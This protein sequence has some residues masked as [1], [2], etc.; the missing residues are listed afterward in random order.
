MAIIKFFYFIRKNCF[1]LTILKWE[2]EMIKKN[3]KYYLTGGLTDEDID[4]MHVAMLDIIEDVGLKV[5]HDGIL[6]LLAGKDGV[7]IKGDIVKFKPELVEK[8]ISEMEYPEYAIN[9]DYI[10]NGGAYEMNVI[11]LDSGKIRPALTSDLVDMVKLVDSYG[12]YASSPVRPTDIKSTELQEIT[13]YKLC[14]ENSSNV[15]NSIFE[16]NEKSSLRVAEYIYEMAQISGKRYSLGFWVKSPFKVDFKELDIIYE[17][18]DKKVPLWCATMPIAGATAPIYFP[19]AYVQSMAEVFAGL[20]LLSLINTS[21]VKPVC[22]IID[23][24]RAYAFDFKYASFV[25]GSPEDIIGTLFQVQ[26]NKRY[27]IPVVAKSLL[28]SSNSIDTQ[29]GAEVM[30]HTMAAALAGARIF[31]GAGL[32]SIDEVYSGEKLVIDYEVVQYVK[33]VVEGFR[34]SDGYLSTEIIKEVGIGG[35]FVSHDSTLKDYRNATWEPNVFEHIMLRKWRQMGEPELR[36][37]L[38]AV[39]KERISK[40]SYSLSKDVSKELNKLYN[41]AKEEFGG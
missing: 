5:P 35:E 6:K 9:A 24:I 23:T 30:A 7:K 27:G 37:K 38:R 3:R 36:E 12:M 4:K 25:Y 13:M 10:I 40:H 31:T 41:K 19:G 16:A 34:F 17:F 28:T 29:L 14:W 8:A 15:S 21:E 1:L 39:A 32:L 11:D 20:T 26:L 22:L 2:S 18:L 33:N